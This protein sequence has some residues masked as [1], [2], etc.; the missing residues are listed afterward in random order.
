MPVF[1]MSDLELPI[2][3]RTYREP[4]GPHSV[5][6]RGRDL[7]AGLQHAAARSDCRA[8]AVIGLPADDRDLSV[9]AG[10][11]LFLVDADSARLRD[12]AANALRAEADVEWIR[13]AT[14]P[15]DRLADALLP[16]GAVVLA[17]GSSS[18]MSGPQKLLLEFDG[19]P[20]V[21]SVIEAASDGGCHQI[22]VVYSADEVKA[23]VGVEAELVHNPRARQGMATSLQAGLRAMRPDMEAAVVMLGDQPMVGSRTVAAL[24]RA[25]RREGSRPAVAVARG[26]EGK[27]AP[28]VVL[29]RELWDELMALEGDAGARQLLDRRPELVDVVPALDRLDDVD[30]PE[31]Y[32]NIVRLF[33][34]PKPTPQT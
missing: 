11:R 18:R 14:P 16:V 33:P 23:A 4:E 31:D 34:R 5:V 32:A 12:F 25:W 19:R 17:A 29:A 26:D 8:V 22:V 27:W 9:L 20:M 21:K 2:R 13:S 24:L 28:P 6:V 10:R 7:D 3:G 1:V 15:F 30:T